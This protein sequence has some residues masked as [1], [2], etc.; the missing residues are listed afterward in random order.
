M[1]KMKMEWMKGTRFE[2]FWV[3]GG[4]RR[5]ERREEC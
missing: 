2:D 1:K 4:G 5:R 3:E